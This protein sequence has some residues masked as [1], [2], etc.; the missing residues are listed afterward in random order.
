MMVRV[1]MPCR[2]PIPSPEGPRRPDGRLAGIR[3]GMNHTERHVVVVMVPGRRR[4]GRRVGQCG[5]AKQAKCRGRRKDKLPHSVS[6]LFRAPKRR[7][8]R[9][10]HHNLQI[11]RHRARRWR[12]VVAGEHWITRPFPPTG[13]ARFRPRSEQRCSPAQV[14]S[15]QVNLACSTSQW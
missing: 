10:P 5:R 11:W 15:S 7:S 6:L 12:P 2:R 4:R 9:D 8:H 14:E 1:P 3:P 13:N